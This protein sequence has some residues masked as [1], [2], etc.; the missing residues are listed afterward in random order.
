MRAHTKPHVIASAGRQST[1]EPAIKL[2]HSIWQP[3]ARDKDQTRPHNEAAHDASTRIGQ[4]EVCDFDCSTTVKLTRED[5]PP[6]SR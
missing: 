5:R 1:L 4:G 2:Q 6:M 3:G